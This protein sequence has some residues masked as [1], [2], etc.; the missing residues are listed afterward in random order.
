MHKRWIAVAIISFL[1]SC[2]AFAQTDVLYTATARSNQPWQ[3]STFHVDPATAVATQ[4]GSPVDVN[5]ANLI[6]L[7]VGSLHVIYVWSHTD[8]WVYPTNAD[9]VPNN[10]PSQ[11]LSFDFA[12]PITTFVVDPSGKFAYACLAWA[13]NNGN[14]Y[15]AIYLLTIDSSNGNLT[16]TRQLAA[17]YGPELYVGF[18]GFSFGVTGEH[19]FVSYVDSA[20]FTCNFGFDEYPVNQ[21]TGAL[22]TLAGMIEASSTCA[23]FI[24][25]AVSD[26]LTGSSYNCCGFN[27]GEIRIRRISTGQQIDCKGSTHHFCGDYGPIY[28]DPASQNFFVNDNQ[29]NLLFVSRIDFT[30]SQLSPTAQLPASFSLALQFSPDD[31]LFY[32]SQP[33]GVNVYSF[34]ANTGK[35]GAS[36]VIAEQQQVALAATILP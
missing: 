15:A 16:N 22:G 33:S 24:T 35:V 14:N 7:T 8:V 30:H 6:P 2:S 28:F 11:H 18:V 10:Q 19:L 29:L 13:D 26:Q 25:L 4:V 36:T 32:T 5:T 3:L 31:R 27:S 9:G 1:A 17:S 21:N 23:S 34:Q 20:P 12:R